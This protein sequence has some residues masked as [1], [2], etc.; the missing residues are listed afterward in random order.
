MREPDP[1]HPVID[2]N[3]FKDSDNRIYDAILHTYNPMDDY[4]RLKAV[5]DTFKQLRNNYPLRREYF[6]YQTLNANKEEINILEKTG[7]R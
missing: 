5:P 1:E 4:A 7:F 6:A 3:N 2:V